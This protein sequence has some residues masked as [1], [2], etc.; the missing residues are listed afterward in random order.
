MCIKKT[1]KKHEGFHS[2]KNKFNEK[3]KRLNYTT[4]LFTN[5]NEDNFL[6]S[7]LTKKIQEIQNIYIL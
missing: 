7:F 2:H 5:I 3:C 6:R 4:Y 1:L